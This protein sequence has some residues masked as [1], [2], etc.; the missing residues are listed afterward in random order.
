LEAPKNFKLKLG[1]LRTATTGSGR[2]SKFKIGC[3]CQCQCARLGALGTIMTRM[4]AD[5]AD[6]ESESDAQVA[7]AAPPGL[8]PLFGTLATSTLKIQ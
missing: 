6:S 8:G 5:S 2:G 1:Y 4:P 3:N 7:A